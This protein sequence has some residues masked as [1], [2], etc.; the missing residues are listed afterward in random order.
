[1]PLLTLFQKKPQSAPPQKPSSPQPSKQSEWNLFEEG[2]LLIDMYERT[3]A[4]VVRSLVAGIEPDQLEISLH[5]DMLTIRGV[6]N[7]CEELYDDQYLLRECYWGSFS[8]S[9]II[10]LPVQT[11][12]IQATF[13][14]GVVTIVL[15]KCE[16]EHAIPLMEDSMQDEQ[17]PEIEDDESP[18]WEDDED[19]KAPA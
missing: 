16:Q 15:P 3:D 12:A 17:L 18:Y 2:Q 13:K 4:I 6:R 1:M 5:N 14:N 8:R 7:D 11:D 9:I 10:P 19:E